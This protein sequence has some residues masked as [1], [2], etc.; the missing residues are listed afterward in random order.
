[1]LIQSRKQKAICHDVKGDRIRLFSHDGKVRILNRDSRC[2]SWITI[3]NT[4][5]W[6]VCTPN[7]VEMRNWKTPLDRDLR[8]AS[9]ITNL[10]VI[11]RTHGPKYCSLNRDSRCASRITIQ[12]THYAVVWKQSKIQLGKLGQNSLMT[13]YDIERFQVTAKIMAHVSKVYDWWGQVSL[14]MTIY[15]GKV[16]IK[17]QAPMHKIFT[18]I[19]SWPVLEWVVPHS[20]TGFGLKTDPIFI[21]HSRYCLLCL[22]YW[23]SHWK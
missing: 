9:Q 1:M 23:H 11:W 3:R 12:N 19:Y 16:N 5:F 2:A 18:P 14:A 8:C 20:W 17:H 21:F 10:D 4:V 7:H 13:Y 22:Q 15:K 6:T